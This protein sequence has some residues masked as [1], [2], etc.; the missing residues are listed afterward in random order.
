MR[1]A[2]REPGG[3]A[4]AEDAEGLGDLRLDGLHRDAEY[5]GDL[6]MAQAVDAAELEDLAATRGEGGDGVVQRGVDLALDE[7]LGGS[8]RREGGADRIGLAAALDALVP[9]VVQRAIARGAEE[10]RAEGLLDDQVGAPA[11]ELEEDVLH[12][13][14]RDGAAAEDVLGHPDQR[15]IVGTEK[16]IEGRLVAPSERVEDLAI[17][18]LRVTPSERGEDE[19]ESGPNA[20]YFQRVYPRDSRRVPPGGRRGIHRIGCLP[21]M[22]REHENPE[23]SDGHPGDGPRPRGGP[24]GSLEDRLAGLAFRAPDDLDVDAALRRV[25]ARMEA[26]AVHVLPRTP[27]HRRARAW[28]RMS[29]RLAAGLA[30]VLGAA[31]LH[32][33]YGAERAPGAASLATRSYATGVGERDSVHLPD[34]SFVLLGPLSRLEVEAAYRAGRRG[35]KLQGE[36][37]FDVRHDGAQPFTVE[38]GSARIHDVGTR[39]SVRE[40][41]GEGVAVVV[42]AGAVLLRSATSGAEDGV[43]LRAGQRGTLRPAGRAE[44]AEGA[45]TAAALAWAQGRLVFQDAS[46]DR[47]ASELRRWYGLELR[48]ADP[49]LAGRHVTASFSGEPGPQVVRVIALALGT[50][51]QIRGDTAVLGIGPATAP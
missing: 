12:H 49:R 18:H 9:A 48:L 7:D 27:S 21:G 5:I 32:R 19:C 15:G 28:T 2:L 14:L 6:G 47:V 40:A 45:D 50:H 23:R 10:I 26:P 39:F 51:A 46:L 30:L 4:G 25:H 36:A 8:G 35:V 3:E 16:G 44:V 37:L 33:R 13:V 42:T 17:I 34:G 41:G 22:A 20:V 29:L 31:L 43:L 38:A 1:P 11:P 24:S